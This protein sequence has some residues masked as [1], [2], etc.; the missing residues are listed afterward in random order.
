VDALFARDLY[1]VMGSV[2]MASVLLIL[3]NLVADI[4]LAWVDP[5]ISYA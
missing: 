2:M 1:L 4:L 5:R 3:S